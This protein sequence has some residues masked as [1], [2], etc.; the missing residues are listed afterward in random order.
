MESTGKPDGRLA[1][2]MQG[3]RASFVIASSRGRG[4]RSA[5]ACRPG[6]APS[7]ERVPRTRDPGDDVRSALRRLLAEG[8]HC[9]ARDG[10]LCIPAPTAGTPPWATPRRSVRAA[11][12]G[13]GEPAARDSAGGRD[14]CSRPRSFA[15][16]P[17]QTARRPEDPMTTA[18]AAPR[19]RFGPG[20]SAAAGQAL[21]VPAPGAHFVQLFRLLEREALD[22]FASG[23]VETPRRIAEFFKSRPIASHERIR[24][25]FRLRDLQPDNPLEGGQASAAR[26]AAW[27]FPELR[28][29]VTTSSATNGS[30]TVI[31][32]DPRVAHRGHLQ[33]VA[34]RSRP[35]LALI[36]TRGA[37][38]SRPSL[39]TGFPGLASTRR[40]M[41]NA[42]MAC[43]V[44]CA[45]A[46]SGE[47]TP[48][49]QDMPT[50]RARVR[51]RRLESDDGWGR[52]VEG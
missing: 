31:R 14:A 45:P 33:Q 17:D 28:Q 3:G 21:V 34:D 1:S 23:R 41:L 39:I 42:A 26:I 47:V 10:V 13:S 49:S 27:S 12:S 37:C 30:P 20:I 9:G 24:V 40:E 2:A 25:R 35:R 44:R 4:G 38:P 16:R 52:A 32:A 22:H 8:R 51:R 43:G 19:D 11:L 18:S 7:A 48:R 15:S 6:A 5:G 29:Y 36:S 46:E 50:W